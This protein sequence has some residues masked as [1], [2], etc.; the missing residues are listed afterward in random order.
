MSMTNKLYG[1]ETQKLTLSANKNKIFNNQSR[2]KTRKEINKQKTNTESPVDSIQASPFQ[3]SWRI[4]WAKIKGG[5]FL[6]Q[7]LHKLIIWLRKRAK[8][9]IETRLIFMTKK[10]W[11]RKWSLRAFLHTTKT[12]SNPLYTKIFQSRIQD[13]DR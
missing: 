2:S 3:F 4:S 8:I 1:Y 7:C 13:W 12:I 6:N 10:T 5:L 11:Q 9:I